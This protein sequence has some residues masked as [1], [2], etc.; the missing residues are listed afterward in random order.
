V[1]NRIHNLLVRRPELVFWLILGYFTLSVLLRALRSDSLQN[2]EAEQAFQAQFLLLGYG[3]Q[4]PFY[5]WLQIGMAELFGLSIFTI[6][7]LKNVLLFLCCLFY[8]L[9]ARMLMDDRRLPLVAML[10]VLAVPSVT[11]LAQRDL[12]HATA[13]L[14]LVSLFLCV[15]IRTL[16]QPSLGSYIMLGITVGIGA[17]TKYNFVIV[18]LAA[19]LAVLPEPQFRK[20]LLDVRVLAALCAAAVVALPH[21]IWAVMHLDAATTG[22]VEAMREGSSGD[23]LKDTIRGLISILLS[24]IEGSLPVILL[25]GLVFWRDVGAAWRAESAWTRVIGRMIVVCIVLVAVI[26]I[27]FGA[28]SIRQKW[29]SPFLLLLPLYLS[30]KFAA[31]RTDSGTSVARMAPPLMGIVTGFIVY[32]A[33]SNIIGPFLGKYG[34]EHIPYRPM[35][36]QVLAQR[37]EHPA[38]ILTDDLMT[39]GNTR[40]H[41]P[42]VPVMMPGFDQPIPLASAERRGSGLLIWPAGAETDALPA[43]LADLVR[44]NGVA[45]ETVPIAHLDVPYNFSRRGDSMRFGYAWL[46]QAPQT[47]R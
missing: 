43:R 6:S 31:A 32:L 22:T 19:A 13:T 25:F 33:L 42:A 9:A 24:T 47:S 11:I 26:G 2:D 20:R 41:Y 36:E 8:W 12:T 46:E 14:C 37:G 4:P 44:P 18:P 10:G 27:G 16:K 5:N 38:Y 7:L 35:L 45:P 3:R 23:P 1:S 40:L 17:I 21:L 28:S 15:F 39:A 30:L 34:K 29:L